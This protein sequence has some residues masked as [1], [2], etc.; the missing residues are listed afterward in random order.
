MAVQRRGRG[1][2]QDRARGRTPPG[3]RSRVPVPRETRGSPLPARSDVPGHRA[4]AG[5]AT[6][7]QG[8]G[9]G[10]SPP[11]AAARPSAGNAPPSRS[12][13]EQN[14][15]IAVCSPIPQP[16]GH[17][18]GA[19]AAPQPRG[20]PCR[21]P[22]AA[23]PAPPGRDTRALPRQRGGGSRAGSGG[24]E[25]WGGSAILPSA[26]ARA[27]PA[28]PG[29]PGGPGAACAQ[30]NPPGLPGQTRHGAAGPNPGPAPQR[31]GPAPCSARG[32]PRGTRSPEPRGIPGGAAGA[33]AAQ[34]RSEAPQGRRRGQGVPG[35]E[36]GAR[37]GVPRGCRP[38]EGE[39]LCVP[40]L[41][42]LWGGCSKKPGRWRYHHPPMS[43]FSTPKGLSQP[44][45]YFFYWDV[46]Q[47]AAAGLG[48]GMGRSRLGSGHQ[49]PLVTARHVPGLCPA[50]SRQGS[51]AGGSGSWSRR[52]PH[53]CAPARSPRGRSRARC[54]SARALRWGSGDPGLAACS[55]G[56]S[57]PRGGLCMA[58]GGAGQGPTTPRDAPPGQCP[59]SQQCWEML[60]PHPCL[61]AGTAGTGLAGPGHLAQ[62]A[63][64][65]RAVSGGWMVG[66]VSWDL[67]HLP[68]PAQGS[69]KGPGGEAALA[70]LTQPPRDGTF[71][72]C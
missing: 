71:E 8:R 52:H 47:P 4:A 12:P 34:G 22:P 57:S 44:D 42:P 60:L 38:T 46:L 69:G 45:F 54:S 24:R 31:G 11:P 16:P 23:P 18:G 68:H 7:R 49:H 25:R 64:L 70:G 55:P 56:G 40:P 26:A 15:L 50:G 29:D 48:S 39:G 61:G 30:R 10:C 63:A 1:W 9:W 67:R 62:D 3:G 20:A 35:W 6:G 13:G 17:S 28:E 36:V 58:E 19:A 2:R 53:P 37:V 66:R 43:S 41:P 32:N 21:A 27:P 51:R 65:F 5:G 59:L 33:A 14:Q 72:V